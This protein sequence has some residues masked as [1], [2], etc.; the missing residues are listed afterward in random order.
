MKT[1]SRS[2]LCHSVKASI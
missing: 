1:V 2:G